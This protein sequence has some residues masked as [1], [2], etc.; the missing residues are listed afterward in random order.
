MELVHPWQNALTV[1]D[2]GL[3]PKVEALVFDTTASNTGIW[4]GSTT[5]FE[6]M[7]HRSV[8]WLACRHHIPELFVKHANTIVRGE[9]K[10]PD[11]PLFKKF[12]KNFN[13]I[14]LEER[15]V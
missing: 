12:A 4:K 13:F 14:N 5:R 8:F 15:E 3:L 11:D 10:G 7:L 6:K 1:G 2:L 9:S